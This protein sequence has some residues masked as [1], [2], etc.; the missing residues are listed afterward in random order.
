M[1]KYGIILVS[2]PPCVG[3]STLL[4]LIGKYLN[5]PVAGVGDLCR[6]EV[7]KGT[8]MGNIFK[9]YIDSGNLI[10]YELIIDFLISVF[11]NKDFANGFILDGYVRQPDNI[12]CLNKIVQRLNLH[13]D[14]VI[15]LTADYDV[16]INRLQSRIAQNEHNATIARSDD[17][18]EIYQ[19]R[20]NDYKTITIP[21]IDHYRKQN[22]VVDIDCNS[23]DIDE[24]NNQIISKLTDFFPQ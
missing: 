22:I 20:Y 24:K 11:S 2:G 19:K 5:L 8:D 6:A 3:K 16:L 17:K 7:A 15:N 9:G 4:P 18:L 13:I 21:V 14:V 23:D 1:S 10:P 12:I